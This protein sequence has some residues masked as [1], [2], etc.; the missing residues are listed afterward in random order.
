MTTSEAAAG[1]T[2]QRWI[3]H[4]FGGSS[5]ADAECIARVAGIIEAD[6]GI[7][8]AVVLSACKGVTDGLLEL[9]AL[10]E[11]RSPATSERLAAIEARHTGIAGTLLDRAGA[12]AYATRLAADCRDIGGILEAVSLIRLAAQNIRDLIAGYGEIWSTRL[13]AALLVQRG[14]RPGPVRWIDARQAVV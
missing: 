4:K 2:D 13:F 3:V 11:Q 6:P 9:V 5:V 1:A 14:H 12:A 8:V 10:A 7:R